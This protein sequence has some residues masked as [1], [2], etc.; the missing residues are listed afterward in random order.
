M[1]ILYT[2]FHAS[3]GK[4]G[5]SVYI[6]SLIEELVRRHRIIV[7]S[8]AGS[9]L[10]RE[11][12]RIDG[13]QVVDQSYANRIPQ[14][15]AGA[16]RL[17]RLIREQ[18]V[19]VVHVNG[20]SD[21]RTVLLACLGLGAMRPAIVFTKHNDVPVS[22]FGPAIRARLGTDH[23][24]GVSW[25]VAQM[26]RESPYALRPI[27]AIANGVDTGRFSPWPAHARAAQREILLGARARDCRLLLGSNAGTDDYKGWIDMV[28]AVRRL[29]PDGEGIY[30]ALAGSGISARQQEELAATGVQDRVVFTGHLDDV[31]PFLAALDVGFVLSR[32]EGI[33]IACREMMAMGLPVVV[34][35][36]GGLPENVTPRV[37]GW[38]VPSHAPDGVAEVLGEILDDP[39]RLAPL[40][41]AARQKSV[42]E[43][44]VGDF[45]RRTEEVYETAFR[46][47][48]RATD[49]SSASVG[50]AGDARRQES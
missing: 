4:G 47:R 7:A 22:R 27:S 41:M 12:R 48:K 1:N 36:A 38:I 40:G 46:Q 25:H 19:D 45:A 14:R 34:S 5:H 43:F 3:P 21:H 11:A 23:A 29:G 26:L 18:R 2:N 35:N 15:L 17:R 8:P 24:I 50:L 9:A 6:L 39:G 13:V 44:S 16:R 37:D 33:S 10:N 49:T 30:I 31:R 28:R 20:S 32:R 42:A